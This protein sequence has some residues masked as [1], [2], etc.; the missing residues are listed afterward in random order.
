MGYKSSFSSSSSCLCPWEALSCSFY[1]SVIVTAACFLPC[2]PKDAFL[3]STSRK[4]TGHHLWHV[5]LL[6]C[7][8]FG[9]MLLLLVLGVGCWLTLCLSNI[10]RQVIWEVIPVASHWAS[11]VLPEWLLW[12]CLEALVSLEVIVEVRDLIPATHEYIAVADKAY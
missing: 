8:P 5:L 3:V 4:R 6:F 11:P 7:H 2:L 9:L 12:H 10:S 1:W